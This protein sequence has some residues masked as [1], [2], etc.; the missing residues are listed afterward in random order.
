MAKGGTEAGIPDFIVQKAKQVMETH[1][2]SFRK[3]HQAGVKIIVGID[4][5]TSL[6]PHGSIVQEMRLMV[7]NGLTPEEVLTAATRVAADALG[8]ENQIGTIEPGKYADLFAVDGDPL[9]DI[10]LLENIIVPPTKQRK[11]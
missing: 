1:Y 8:L 9:S 11:V 5:G 10:D 6:N 4:Q 3:A 7:E 2:E